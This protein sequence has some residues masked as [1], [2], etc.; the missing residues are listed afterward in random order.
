MVAEP[1]KT[2]IQNKYAQQWTDDLESNRIRQDQLAQELKQ[3]KSDE[4]W[5]LNHLSSLPSDT[6]ASDDAADDKPAAPTTDQADG[7]AEKPAVVPQPQQGAPAKAVSSKAVGADTGTRKKSPAKKT[8]AAKPAARKK[9]AGKAPVQ[10]SVAADASS[11]PD[12]APARPELALPELMLALLLTAPG[13]PRTTAELHT[14]LTQEHPERKPSVQTVR[15]SL[16]RLVATSRITRSRQG[17]AVM[18]TAGTRAEATAPSQDS[19]QKE[20]TSQETGEKVSAGAQ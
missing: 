7:P 11:A 10:K 13:E 14:Q 1:V 15:N 4:A 12:K 9:S 18:Y 8:T 19:V 20:Q 2:T 17:H 3:L 6:P 16:E 5:L